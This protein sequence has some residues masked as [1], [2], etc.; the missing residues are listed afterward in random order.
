MPDLHEICL[1]MSQS[2]R[3]QYRGACYLD[4]EEHA[5]R[6]YIGCASILSTYRLQIFQHQK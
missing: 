2:L 1:Y 5:A 3:I 4:Q 6:K